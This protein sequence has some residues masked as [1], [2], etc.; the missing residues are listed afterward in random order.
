M[1]TRVEN[2]SN[3]LPLTWDEEQESVRSGPDN[4]AFVSHSYREMGPLLAAAPQM[5][6]TLQTVL[7]WAK[8]EA[9]A[10]ACTGCDPGDEGAE[11]WG[12]LVS[13]IEEAIKAAKEGTHS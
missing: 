12:G 2:D 3:Y 13:E 5:L 8:R 6:K 11:V 1:S 9:D 10:G 7:P 4:V